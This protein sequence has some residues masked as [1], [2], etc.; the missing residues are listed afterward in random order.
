M[1]EVKPDEELVIIDG[2]GITEAGEALITNVTDTGEGIEPESIICLNC[3][4]EATMEEDGVHRNVFCGKECQEIY[5]LPHQTCQV[6]DVRHTSHTMETPRIKMIP[7]FMFYVVTGQENE[8]E[9]DTLYTR[10]IRVEVGHLVLKIYDRN[11]NVS[12]T[13]CLAPNRSCLAIIPPGVHYSLNAALAEN[14]VCVTIT[15]VQ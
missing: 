13:Y 11:K 15:I 7:Q 8:I 12:A 14:D 10:M 6:I 3:D 1:D 5:R 4:K 2:D 9:V